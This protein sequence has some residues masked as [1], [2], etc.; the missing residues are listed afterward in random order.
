MT[1]LSESGS[2]I[3]RKFIR[4][5]IIFYFFWDTLYII[6]FIDHK[7]I[8]KLEEQIFDILKVSALTNCKN[9]FLHKFEV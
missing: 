6:T 5:F 8:Y 1:L 9:G 4:L 2:G 3:I 7:M